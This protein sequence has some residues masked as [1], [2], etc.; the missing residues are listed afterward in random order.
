MQSW[1]ATT[2]SYYPAVIVNGPIAKQI[3]LN[4]GYGCH[5][6]RSSVPGRWSIGRAIR[7]ILMNL[8]GAIPGIGTMAIYGGPARYTNAVF[9]EDEDWPSLGLG[10]A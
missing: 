1:N 5:G 2:G 7:F 4:S 10:T 9:A 6:S 3:R 8:G